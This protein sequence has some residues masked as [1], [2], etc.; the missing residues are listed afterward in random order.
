MKQTAAIV[1]FPPGISPLIAKNYLE[2]VFAELKPPLVGSAPLQ[3]GCV[4]TF[5]PD[6]GTPVVYQP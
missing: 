4:D 1:I 5:N 2:Q 3:V 6:L